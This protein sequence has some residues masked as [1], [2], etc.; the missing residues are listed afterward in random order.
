MNQT[1][2]EAWLQL[3]KELG[4]TPVY[5]AETIQSNEAE[6]IRNYL[7]RLPNRRLLVLFAVLST[8][9]VI[10]RMVIEA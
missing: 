9:I 5:S 8:V 6:F 4:Q 3:K 1:L 10:V 2:R 7:R